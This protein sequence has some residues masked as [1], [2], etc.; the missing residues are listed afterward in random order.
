MPAVCL[1]LY[2]QCASAH[3]ATQLTALHLVVHLADALAIAPPPDARLPTV[4]GGQAPRRALRDDRQQ[5]RAHDGAGG[6]RRHPRG[7][8]HGLP[9]SN[10]QPN[11]G[12]WG[13]RVGDGSMCGGWAGVA[14]HAKAA[15]VATWLRLLGMRCIAWSVSRQLQK[16]QERSLLFSAGIED[17][18]RLL[19]PALGSRMAS[20]VFAIAL[21][22]SGQNSTI[23][24][25]L[26]GQIVMEGF[27]NLRVRPESVEAHVQGLGQATTCGPPIALSCFS[28]LTATRLRDLNDRR[29][30]PGCGG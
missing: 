22:A 17:A 20:T 11:R 13:G 15:V 3:A 16:S 26:S 29:W 12:R 21:L 30:R 9:L 25:T 10:G 18:Y 2:L 23:T 28:F 7:R 1:R 5:R 6:Q 14:P 8:G 4:G 27:V 19:D 24:G